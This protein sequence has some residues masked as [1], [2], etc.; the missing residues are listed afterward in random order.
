MLRRKRHLSDFDSPWKEALQHFLPRFLAFFYP[1]IYADI[2]WS[3]GYQSL[4]K[5][6]HQLI[7]DASFPR[8]WPTNSSR[9]G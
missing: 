3:K 4:D 6:L 7:R 8:P 1:D 9:S 5:E 2:D